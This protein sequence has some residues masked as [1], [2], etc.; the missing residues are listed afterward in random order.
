MIRAYKKVRAKNKMP[1]ACWSFQKAWL[2][3]AE[4]LKTRG[5][6]AY[7]RAEPR[8]DPALVRTVTV[9]LLKIQTSI[10]QKF[11]IPFIP[12]GFE[13]LQHKCIVLAPKFVF[14]RSCYSQIL[15]ILIFM[16][17]V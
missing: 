15:D 2:D 13:E 17:Y 16:G 4:L 11:L 7:I 10:Y 5:F 8:L 3:R 12:H 9:Q 1:R 14:K 6:R